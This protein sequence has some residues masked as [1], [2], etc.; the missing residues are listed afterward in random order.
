MSATSLSTTDSLKVQLAGGGGRA[1]TLYFDLNGLETVTL[2]VL[3]TVYEPGPWSGGIVF[4][5]LTSGAEFIYPI[6]ADI[7]PIPD[8]VITPLDVHFGTLLLGETVIQMFDFTNNGTVPLNISH[9]VTADDGSVNLNLVGRPSR[10]DSIYFTVLPGQTEN[11]EMTAR[12][13]TLGN[14]SCDMHATDNLSR[15]WFDFVVDAFVLPNIHFVP[16]QIN[17]GEITQGIPLEGSSSVDP[18][19]LCDDML[20]EYSWVITPRGRSRVNTV[21]LLD[22]EGEWVD[23]LVITMPSSY[24][25][26]LTFRVMPDTPGPWLASLEFHELN[27]DAIYIIPMTADV[28][29]P[30]PVLHIDRAEDMIRLY[31]EPNPD[32]NS[33]TVYQSPGPGGPFVPIMVCPPSQTELYLPAEPTGF[34]KLTYEVVP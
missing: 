11:V 6:T 28:L 24:P 29:P 3:L 30:P 27:S 2:E 10:A 19:P 12:P 31:W 1:D 4:T 16:P 9:Y 13:Q 23:S 20:A 21:N 5:E 15:N 18:D 22:P 33:F 32:A 7:L 8:L 34:F 26:D 17:L 25:L 14:W